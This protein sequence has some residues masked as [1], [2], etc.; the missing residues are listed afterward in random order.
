MSTHPPAGPLRGGSLL[1]EPASIACDPV[2]RRRVLRVWI[3]MA[4]VAVLSAADLYMTLTY[5][6]TVG[7]GEANPLARWVIGYNSAWL[8]AAWKGA[9]IALACLIFYVFRARRS[10]EFAAWVC[11]LILA[12]LSVHWLRYAS[13]VELLTPTLH[14]VAQQADAAGNWV[15]LTD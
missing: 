5:L 9:S 4:A 15:T 1:P 11:M 8:L 12:A 14:V 6:R 7:M 3:L 13:Q 2:T 10:G